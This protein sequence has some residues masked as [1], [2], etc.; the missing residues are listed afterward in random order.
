[1]IAMISDPVQVA[2]RHEDL[3]KRLYESAF[4]GVAAFV[5]KR[6]GTLQDAKDIFQDALVIFY[7]K[8]AAGRLQINLSE[9]AYLLGIAKHLW[10][11]KFNHDKRNVSF[12]ELESAIAIPND[13]FAEVHTGRLL[14]FLE[15]TGKRCMDLLMAFYYTRLSMQKIREEFGY[16]SERS[17]TVQKYK[18]LEK[19]RDQVKERSMNYDDFTE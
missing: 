5:S 1:M 18:C 2:E 6:H 7:E 14:Q 4:P 13:Y 15:L 10:I 19:I 8:L 11:R 16:G 12:T 9:E 17:A 3:F